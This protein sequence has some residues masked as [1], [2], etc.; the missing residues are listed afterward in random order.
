MARRNKKDKLYSSNV[1]IEAADSF[2]KLAHIFIDALDDD[3]VKSHQIAS[4]D[5]G[6]L[7]SSATTLALSVELYLKSLRII[8]GLSVPEK[9]HLW[10]L[11][12]VLPSNIKEHIESNYNL[13]NPK[14]GKDRAALELCIDTGKTN[15]EQLK[16]WLNK[17]KRACPSGSLKE[18]LVYSSDAF[19]TWRY[20]HETNDTEDI[21][22]ISYEYLRLDL[23][24]HLLRDTCMQLKHNNAF[25]RDT[26]KAPRPLT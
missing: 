25:K 18:V 19:Q 22:V 14:D 3:I 1:S 6:G 8:L 17:N 13:Q 10:S 4:K 21:F 20:L 26:E 9:H 23:I 11:Y 15:K 5:V 16:D 24:A 12:K 2:R 7:I